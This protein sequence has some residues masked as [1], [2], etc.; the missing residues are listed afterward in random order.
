MRR[1]YVL[2]VLLFTTCCFS[3]REAANWYFGNNAGLDFNSGNPVAILDG[4]IATIEGCSAISDFNGNLLFYT[5]G[6]T[7]WNKM[8]EIMPNGLELKGS[9]SSAQSALIV[10]SPTEDNIY[11]IFT[12]DDALLAD[13]GGF[14]GFNYSI[15]DMNLDSFKG[16]VITKNTELLPKCSEKVSGVYNVE[17]DFYWIVTQFEDKFYAYKITQNGVEENPVISTTGPLIDNPRNIRGNLKISPD[18][19]LL[20]I[21]HT[22]IEPNF[23]SSFYIF[24][25]DIESGLVSNPQ[26]VEDS[27]IYYGLEF[28]ANSS[29][30]YASGFD[31]TQQNSNT[32]L[33]QGRIVQFDLTNSSFLDEHVLYTFL[34]RESIF[35]AGALQIGIDK[36]IYHS[37]PSLRLS[38]INRPNSKG[39]SAEFDAFSVGLGDRSATYGLPSFVQSYFKTIFEIANFCYG[40]ETTFIAETTGDIASISWN[41]DDPDS[42]A[43]NFSNELNPSHLFS[44][45]GTYAVLVVVEYSNGYSEEFT[46]YVSIAETPAVTV[47][48]ELVQCDLDGVDDGSSLFNLNEALALFNFEN[49]DLKGLFFATQEDAIQDVNRLNPLAYR[50]RV[51]N[52][53]IYI[54][55]FENSECFSISEIRLSVT[56]L[57][58]L[59]NYATL[60]L[61]NTTRGGNNNLLDVSE[62]YDLLSEDFLGSAITVYRNEEDALF[63]TNVLQPNQEAFDR[64]D[65]LEAYFRIENENQ[66]AFIGRIGLDFVIV[67]PYDEVTQV[68]LCKG[69]FTLSALEGFENYMW[70]DGSTEQEY[71][72]SSPGVVDVIFGNAQCNY[73]QTFEVL[74]EKAVAIE[75]VEI[76]D[77]QSNNSVRIILGTE[78]DVTNT[79]FS[80][81]GGLNFQDF[82]FFNNVLPGV[83]NLVVDNG[84]A[85]SE[86]QIIVG[87]VPSF[88]TPNND[89]INDIWNMRNASYFPNFKISIFDRYGKMIFSFDENS[90]GWDGTFNNTDMPANDYW[91]SLEMTEGKTFKGFFTL[92]R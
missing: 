8:H 9:A 27:R 24:D 7:V 25:F 36:K 46:E 15:V 11:Y 26:I 28:S 29:M 85:I 70:P 14:N 38:R 67:P 40:D 32:L 66:C 18:G 90:N 75:S 20:A 89:S 73:I 52:E 48:S 51:N 77:F 83:Y 80:I 42:G 88:F 69:T 39:P 92:K 13:S 64:G 71:I 58:D 55:V 3:Q 30:L 61:C 60:Y 86:E 74:P 65:F 47:A 87:G 79:Y 44:N 57:S 19:S 5:D 33:G 6:R 78:E 2:L 53:T 16:D 54:R 17:G 91:Y 45:S 49:S 84:C 82:N 1:V 31:L 72:V 62:V 34:N 22:I 12:T 35:V 59:G 4:Q 68:N 50:N 63:K 21:T 43:A 56:P 10:Q 76:D 23:E 37:V 81:D 41:F